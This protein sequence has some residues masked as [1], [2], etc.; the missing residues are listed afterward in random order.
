MLYLIYIRVSYIN[1]LNICLQILHVQIPYHYQQA[2]GK[3]VI[4]GHGPLIQDKIVLLIL[5]IEQVQLAQH[6]PQL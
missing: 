3:Q 6:Q 2:Y 5:N 1:Y 4:E